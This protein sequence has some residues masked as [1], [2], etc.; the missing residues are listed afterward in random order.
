M[1]AYGYS[2]PRTLAAKMY[3]SSSAVPTLS[4]LCTVW[5]RRIPVSLTAQ[6]SRVA[7]EDMYGFGFENPKMPANHQQHRG[8]LIGSAGLKVQ[9]LRHSEFRHVA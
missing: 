4:M 8:L 5:L 2:R 7:S 3:L 9:R 6:I 1:Q